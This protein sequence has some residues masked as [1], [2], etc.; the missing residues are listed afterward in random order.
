MQNTI[1]IPCL[2]DIKKARERISPYI[3]K[4][5][6]KYSQSLSKVIDAEIF[7]KYENLNPT[8]AFKV[9]GGI[10]FALKLKENG[11][12]FNGLIAGSTGNHGQSIAYAGK[13][14]NIPTIIAVPEN[15]NP[16]K[17]QAMKDLGAQVIIQGKDTAETWAWCKKEASKNGY[18]Y[19]L[20]CEEPDLFEGVGTIGLEILEN[21]PDVECYI[22][23]VGGGSGICGASIALK[24]TNPNIK[25]YAVQAS[26]ASAVYDSFKSKKLVTHPSLETFAEGLATRQMYEYPFNIMQKYVDDMF[27]VSD[28][29]LKRA[30]YLILEHTKN[31]AEG[32]GAAS[33]AGLIKHKDLF[34]GKKIV[35]CLTGGNLPT[36]ILK[37]IIDK[38]EKDL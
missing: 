26:G 12:N 9:R 5:P 21:L 1:R 7:I 10:N 3:T 17:I 14:L 27:V 35:C 38:Y 13:I 8:N 18:R 29:E 11:L 30:I 20:S 16:V 25:T 24:S 2:E 37:E 23:A 19:V 36:K 6:L 15:A 28:D 33:L 34:K 31:I 4:T 22:T 32:A